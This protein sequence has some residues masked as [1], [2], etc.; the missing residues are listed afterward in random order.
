MQ[1]DGGRFRLSAGDLS[2][3]LACRHLTQLDRA[4]AEGRLAPPSWQDPSLALLQERGLAHERGYVEHLRAGGASVVQLRDVEG[5]AASE[6]T[7]TA[8]RE[9]AGAIVQAA[10]ED[11]PWRGRADILLRVSEP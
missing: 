7:L 8:M 10:L 9:G 4:V 2:N 11:G 6:R 5:A 3:H 1:R